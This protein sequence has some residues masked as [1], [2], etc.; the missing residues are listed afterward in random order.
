[1]FGDLGY[2]RAEDMPFIPVLT[3]D[4]K[5]VVYGPQADMPVDPDVVLLFVKPDQTL[6][7]SEASQRLENGLPPAL[8]HAACANRT[9]RS[10]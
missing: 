1:M 10:Q 2:V 8:G 9:P 7:L 4:A 3:R 5:A 6:I